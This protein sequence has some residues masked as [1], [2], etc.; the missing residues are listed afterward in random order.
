[1]V[2]DRS[3]L[4]LEDALGRTEDGRNTL[5]QP[6]RARSARSARPSSTSYAAAYQALSGNVDIAAERPSCCIQPVFCPRRSAIGRR[7]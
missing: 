7:G 5:A 1:M 3:L 2:V 6:V 4:R